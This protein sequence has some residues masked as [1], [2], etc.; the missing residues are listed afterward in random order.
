MYVINEDGSNYI[1]VVEPT[2][3]SSYR[4]HRRD[5]KSDLSILKIVNAHT[6]VIME[7]KLSVNNPINSNDKDKL[8]QFYETR[9]I[10]LK[11]G[12]KYTQVRSNISSTKTA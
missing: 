7:V 2:V 8:A 12:R 3:Y 11:E 9:L 10:W 5:K 1:A 6:V 4:D